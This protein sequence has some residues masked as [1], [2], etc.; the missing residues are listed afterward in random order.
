MMELRE[1]QRRSLDALDDYFHGVA[2][3]GANTAFYDI[4]RRSY[5]EIDQLPA[6]PYVCLRVPTGGGKTLMACHSLG[7]ACR[8]FLQAERTVC[9]WLVPSNAIRDQTL[10]AL[11]N[12]QHPYRQAIEA[13]FSGNVRVTDLAEALYVQRSSLAAETVIIVSTLQAFRVE[14][15]EGRKVYESAG[16]LSH[17]FSGLPSNLEAVLER[18]DDGTFPHSLANVLRLRRPMV[19]M[20]ECT[21]HARPCR[22]TR[23]PASIHRA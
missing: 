22:S 2:T 9:L 4:T 20:D 18:E 16:A 5:Q 12:R 19:I 1:Y 21:T 23:W 15:T 3:L 17:H 6:L 8:S 14:E 10:S 7:I 11:R 13:D